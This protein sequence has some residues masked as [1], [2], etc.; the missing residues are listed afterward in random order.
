MVIKE[1]QNNQLEALQEMVISA[2]KETDDA[3][4]LDL[5]WRILSQNGK[6]G[7]GR[8]MV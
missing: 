4:L 2:V 1:A 8:G 6:D 7:A 3:D 5:V